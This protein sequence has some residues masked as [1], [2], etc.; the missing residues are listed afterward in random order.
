MI[1]QNKIARYETNN[2]S[3]NA[4]LTNMSSS[5]M[6]ASVV[7]GLKDYMNVSN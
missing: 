5:R 2:S 7:S 1:I 4:T 6:H 3:E